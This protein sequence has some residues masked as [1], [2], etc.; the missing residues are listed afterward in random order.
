[1]RLPWT[2]LAVLLTLV[3]PSAPAVEVEVA[4]LGAGGAAVLHDSRFSPGLQPTLALGV[5]AQLTGGSG[6]GAGVVIEHEGAGASP[7]RD[8]VSYRAAAGVRLR[9]FALWDPSRPGR[10]VSPAL[11][12]GLSGSFLRYAHTEVSFVVPGIFVEP[13]VTFRFPR[14]GWLRLR[15]GLPVM[16]FRRADL[17]FAAGL[18]MGISVGAAAW[19][20]GAAIE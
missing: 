11:R 10:P 12:L 15:L 8:L 18:G 4:A 9:V 20:G 14:A 13:I 7:V 17:R 6:I 3:T 1:M 16:L 19:L 5:L 2:A